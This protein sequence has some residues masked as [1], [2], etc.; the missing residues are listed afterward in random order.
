MVRE[1]LAKENSPIIEELNYYFILAEKAK[2]SGDFEESKKIYR[3][4]I[5]A[6]DMMLQEAS[7]HIRK[8]IEKEEKL[9]EM[10][11]MADQ[12]Y[13]NGQYEKAKKILEKIMEEAK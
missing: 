12:Y 8:R 10:K 9:K 1:E 7:E 2:E 11:I 4:I 5:M 13:K 6:G 3:D